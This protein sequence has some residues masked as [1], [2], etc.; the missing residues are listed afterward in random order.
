MQ[1]LLLLPPVSVLLGWTYLVNDEKI[2][3]IGRYVRDE[4]APRLEQLTSG[5][6]AA[7]IF[8]WENA[9]RRDARRASRKWLQLAVDLL[10]FCAS[11]LAALAVFWALGPVGAPL[12]L[13]SLAELAAIAV[14]GVQIVLY[15]DLAGP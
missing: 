4:L 14:L 2:S 10:A 7:K 1:L 15:A 8:G 6:G 5:H 11:P 12:L 13:V 9:H 3:A